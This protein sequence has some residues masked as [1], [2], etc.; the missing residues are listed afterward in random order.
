MPV[1]DIPISTNDDKRL[2]FNIISNLASIDNGHGIFLTDYP[3]HFIVV[4]DLTGTK[5]A[6]HD[7]IH[8]ELTNCLISI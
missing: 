3:N 5:Q 2:H 7:F 1:A 4:F 6:F 8:P